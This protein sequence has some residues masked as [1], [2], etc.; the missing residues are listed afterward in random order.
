MLAL[1]SVIQ[2]LNRV[3]W[4]F[5]RSG[6]DSGSVHGIH[7]FPGNFISQIPAFLIQILSTPGQ[8]VLDPFGGSGTTAIEALKLG[9][10]AVSIDRVTACDFLTRRKISAFLHP[11]SS[12]A[13][14]R[15]L[16]AT[17]WS[18]EF[19]TAGNGRSGEGSDTRL[20]EWY[21]PR[22]LAQL[23]FLWKLVESF[24]GSDRL[25]LELVFSDLLFASA[26]TGGSKTATGKLRR[27]HW[28]WVA[29]NVR[30]RT[31]IDHEAISGFIARVTSLPNQLTLSTTSAANATA[32]QEDA[33]N[34]SLTDRSVDLVITSPPYVGVI[35]YVRANRMLYLWMGWPF[36]EDREAEIGARF[37]RQRT[38]QR[39]EAEY[40][41]AM[42]QCWSE[43]DRVLKPGGYCAIVIGE[44][45]A[46]PGVYARALADMGK[47]LDLVWGPTPRTPSR[48]RVADRAAQDA[49]E[50]VAV[51]RKP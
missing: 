43:F 15:V 49:V 9:R 20:N 25:I 11:L 10:D 37:K 13:K 29:D 51:F 12:I 32:L 19:T 26:S 30:P 38:R 6:T 28:G 22:T 17:D 35:D 50:V 24:D 8:T 3:N 21:S 14:D 1:D 41:S 45:R 31:L 4:D 36:D 34:L 47:R 5:P 39:V 33:R 16:K 7:W 27:H 18:L 44:S 48:R 2:S 23:R 42:D 46:F 40:I